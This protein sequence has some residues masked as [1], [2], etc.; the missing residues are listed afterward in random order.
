[1]VRCVCPWKHGCGRDSKRLANLLHRIYIHV[2]RFTLHTHLRGLMTM[3]DYDAP[4]NFVA[5]WSD[6]PVMTA[7]PLLI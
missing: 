1:M 3:V 4:A 5:R 7:S 6:S 2:Y